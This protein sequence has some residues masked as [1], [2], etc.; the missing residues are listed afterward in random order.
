MTLCP[1]GVDVW[2]AIKDKEQRLFPAWQNAILVYE[3]PLLKM[4][5]I[6]V[7]I[8]QL[9]FLIGPN[10]NSMEKL[11]NLCKHEE[12]FNGTEGDKGQGNYLRSSEN[13]GVVETCKRKL[14]SPQ[15]SYPEYLQHGRT[16]GAKRNN[17]LADIYGN[18][19]SQPYQDG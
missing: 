5:T 17:P 11:F 2:A 18:S 4:S 13:S 12:N 15:Q 8:G 9:T 16:S 6:I 14:E 19:T 10:E 3:L 7:E 1:D